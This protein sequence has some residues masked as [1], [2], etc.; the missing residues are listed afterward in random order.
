MKRS[1]TRVSALGLS[2]FVASLPAYGQETGADAVLQP[3]DTITIIGRTADV[4]DIP[5]SAHV[6]D[7]EA[8]GV[9]NDTDILR[10]LRAVPGVYVQEEEGFGL[11]P[12][13]G[14]S[15]TAPYGFTGSPERTRFHCGWP[16]HYGRRVEYDF[17]ADTRRAGRQ[18]G[19]AGR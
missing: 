12:N 7:A 16:A 17:D 8:L 4:A 19:S 5:G 13:I 18:C 9:F 10:V 14:I 1:T 2:L 15:D 11:R 6:M 3:I